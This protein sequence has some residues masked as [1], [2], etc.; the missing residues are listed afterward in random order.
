M[1]APR[2]GVRSPPRLEL[3]GSEPSH[4]PQ[5][6]SVNSTEK[7][8]PTERASRQWAVAT[9]TKA[10][11]FAERMWKAISA[12]TSDGPLLQQGLPGESEG[13]V[14]MEK[15]AKMA[16][17]GERPEET[18]TPKHSPS[19]TVAINWT[20]TVT[21]KSGARGSSQKA[22]AQ[23]FLARPATGRVAMNASNERGGRRCNDSARMSA[24]AR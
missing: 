16:P 17:F 4:E 3:S 1:K 10:G 23:K 2:R 11:V 18:T 21:P 5:S 6:R 15:P 12:G 8:T 19:R 13:V 14:A 24:G 7:A 22:S 9:A 20:Y